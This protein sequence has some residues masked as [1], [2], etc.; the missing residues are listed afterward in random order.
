MEEI[1]GPKGDKGDKG[2]IGTVIFI[3]NV[4]TGCLLAY[5]GS[6]PPV[7]FLM[8]DGAEINRAS[9]STLF[10]VISTKFGDGDKIS[11]FKLPDMRDKM[12]VN[13]VIKT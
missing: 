11:T 7:G 2:D 8:C 12:G 5:G 4:P 10:A 6:R 3:T 1:K 9:Y 13:W